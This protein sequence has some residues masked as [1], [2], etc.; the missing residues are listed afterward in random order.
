[1]RDEPWKAYSKLTTGTKRQ[2]CKLESSYNFSSFKFVFTSRENV[3]AVE[4]HIPGLLL[5]NNQ[6]LSSMWI[7]SL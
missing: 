4:Q 6:K 7:S 2:K 5:T 3:H 1:M